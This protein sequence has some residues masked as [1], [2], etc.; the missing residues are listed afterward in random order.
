MVLCLSYL[1][2]SL[3]GIVKCSLCVLVNLYEVLALV[4]HIH[5]DLLSNRVDV[6][7]QL[8]DIIQFLLPLLDYVLHVISLSPYLNLHLV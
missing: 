7:H 3:F 8:F 2:V 4:M 6:T 5:I 1:I